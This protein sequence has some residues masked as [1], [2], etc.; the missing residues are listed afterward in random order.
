MRN[1]VAAL[2]IMGALAAPAQ[3]PFEALSSVKIQLPPDSPV[4]LLSADWKQSRT[5]PRGGALILDLHTAVSLRNAGGRRIRGITL[6]VLAQE[7]TPGGR[8]SVTVPCLNVAP[9]D[10]FPIRIDLRLLRPLPAGAGP[11]VTVSL[12]GVLFEDLSFYGPNQLN[13]RRALTAWELEAQR[14]RR[15]LGAVL[16][17]GG[18]AALQK[19]LLAAI[20]RQAERPRLD[21]RVAR[22]GRA[23][24]F[25]AERTVEFAFLRFPDAP[26]EPVAGT[27]RIT[28]FEAR[29]PRLEVMNRSGRAVR[30]LEIGWLLKDRQ[31]REF[32]AGSVPAALALAPGQKS[33]VMEDST[34]L[35]FTGRP[36]LGLAIDSITGYVSQVEFADGQIWIPSRASLS[37]PRLLRALSPST[38]EERLIG[39][40]KTKGLVAVVGELKKF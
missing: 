24:N 27:A 17:A 23:T 11:L 25:E 14:D 15:H 30:H 8:G 6:Q 3:E 38:E 22:A 10:S 7:V 33:Q 12:D 29:S 28:G 20:A 35:R 21:M 9:G 32:L 4:A 19:E 1:K 26:V 40:Y 39:I 2:I 5:A 36:G 16:S 31:G 18:P 37:D 13:L 34:S